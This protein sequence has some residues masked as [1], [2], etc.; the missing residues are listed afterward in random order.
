MAG[1]RVEV[2]AELSRIAGEF[3]GWCPWVSDAGR[4]W[5][6]RKGCQAADPAAGWAMTVD[7]DDAEGLRSAIAEQERLASPVG[8]V[9]SGAA[10]PEPP[11]SGAG[12]T[13]GPA[14]SYG[15]DGR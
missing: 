5:A 9:S 14:A 2:A 12:A 7:A 8:A 10:R 11:R 1:A 4:W 15:A 13:G 3:P 6:T